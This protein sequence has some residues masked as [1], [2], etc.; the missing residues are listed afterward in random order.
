MAVQSF[1]A[2]GRGSR[3]IRSAIRLISPGR[4]GSV[5]SVSGA[6]GTRPIPAVRYASGRSRHSRTTSE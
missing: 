2:R 6:K 5:T 1:A 4:S 3:L